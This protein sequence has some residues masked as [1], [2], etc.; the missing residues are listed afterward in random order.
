MPAGCWVYDSIMEQIRS[1]IAIELP[2]ELQRSISRLQDQL[3]IKSRAPA[4]WVETG[5][6]HLTLKFLGNINAAIIGDITRALEEAARGIPTIHLN[7]E[8]LGAFPNNNRTQVIWVGLTGDL[9]K[10]R[11]LQRRV[12]TALERLGFLGETR[13]FSPHLTIARLRDWATYSDRQSIGKLIAETAFHSGHDFRV[14]SIHL[15]KSQL[16][17]EGPI[18]SRLGSVGLG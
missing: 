14:S 1:F 13:P 9:E 8:S 2:E 15:M 17:R 12:D 5:N 16:T 4:K 18:Y 10:L 11:N 3:K 7:V 6:I